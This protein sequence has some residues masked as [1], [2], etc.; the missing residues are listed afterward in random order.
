MNDKELTAAQKQTLEKVEAG[1]AQNP[2]GYSTPNR[3]GLRERNKKVIKNTLLNS[4][5]N[6]KYRESFKRAFGLDPL[7]ETSKFPVTDPGFSW[8][9]LEQKLQNLREADSASSFS[10]FLRAG[11]Q[12]INNSRYES[13]ATTYEDWV[14]VVQSSRDTELYA[15]NHGVSFPREVPHSGKYPEVGAA[16]LD[17]QLKNRKFGSIYGV[18]MNLLEDDQTGSFARQAGLMGEYLKLL[19]EVWV[20]GKLQSVSSM[21]YI[22]LSIPTSETKP[23]T[24]S[25]YPW[26]T[27]LVGGGKT[28]PSSFGALTQANIQAGIIAL[29]NQLNL[30]GIRMSVTPTRLIISPHYRFDASVLLHS[31]YYPSGA[32]AAGNVGGAFAI[33]PIKGIL[34]LT[35]SRYVP[36]QNG[37]FTADSKA[38]YIVDDTKPFFILQLREGVGVTAENPNSGRGF[39]EDILRWK[40]RTR[41][42]ADFLDPRFA[43]LGSDGS[44]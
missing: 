27:G 12:A 36:D 30:Q 20:Y 14:T 43:W 33:N 34:D 18:E 38:W 17:I 19:S 39:E 37:S 1:L 11:V 25:S 13:V 41:L 4:P 10:Q 29:M 8:R 42:N 16:A 2:Y 5:E 3:W 22:D 24:E 35:V 28:R 6:K 23:S 21:K 26:S 44:V 31:A 40:A 32:A 15:P 7:V 9:K